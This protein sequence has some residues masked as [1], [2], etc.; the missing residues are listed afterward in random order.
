MRDI[1]APLYRFF[2]ADAQAAARRG[3]EV[4]MLECLGLAL[5]FVPEEH[6][7]RVLMVSAQLLPVPAGSTMDGQDGGVDA[8]LGSG[9]DRS[10]PS[11]AVIVLGEMPQLERLAWEVPV[12][13][14]GAMAAPPASLPI[15][16]PAVDPRRPRAEQTR[17]PRWVRLAAGVALAVVVA[18]LGVRAGSGS[19]PEPIARVVGGGDPVRL[20]REALVDGRP[21][22]ALALLSAAATKPGSSIYC[23]RAEASLALGDTAAAERAW[24]QAAVL[25]ADDG[26][27]ALEAGDRLVEI[28]SVPLAAEAYLYAV[29]PARSGEELRRIAQVQ[30]RAGYVDRA[31]RV[32]SG[33]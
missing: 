16:A 4:R 22:D 15:I 7:E 1:A 2:L 32:L 28:G 6:R 24:T 10:A 26:R 13:P 31:R 23:L 21:E 29:N 30:R 19:L 11:G 18:L 25:D 8:V 3:D 33:R 9:R 5:D 20:A 12:H 27:Y 14:G 17:S